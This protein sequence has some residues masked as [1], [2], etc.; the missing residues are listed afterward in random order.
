[1]CPHFSAISVRNIALEWTVLSL[2]FYA[3]QSN[4]FFFFTHNSLSRLSPLDCNCVEKLS[5]I[6][7]TSCRYITFFSLDRDQFA[8]LVREVAAPDVGRM[9]IEILSFTIKDIYDNEHY[10]DSLGK[11]QTAEV[12]KNAD[13]GVAEANRD[14]GIRVRVAWILY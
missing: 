8:Q 12:K 5:L 1:M 2:V 3:F 13:V 7:P 11:T 14:A 4:G 10:L 6:E 9:G